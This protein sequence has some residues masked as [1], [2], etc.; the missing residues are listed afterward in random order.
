MNTFAPNTEIVL[1]DANG[2]VKPLF[3]ANVLGKVT[4]LRIPGVTG[5]FKNSLLNHN[6][7]TNAGHKAANAKISGQGSYG[8]FTTIAL[9]IG[10]TAAATADTQL[11][12]EITTGGAARQVATGI[13]KVT[14]SV[15]NDTTQL[16][17][18]FNFTASFAVTEEGILDSTTVSGST[19]LAHQVFGA[20]NVNS[21]DSLTITHKYQS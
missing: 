2:N 10:A 8:T 13:S 16:V 4:G 18:T 15:T 9:G 1:R 6:L 3:N 14:T 12:S 11:G 20:I 19:L 7:V 21:G 5:S 17:S